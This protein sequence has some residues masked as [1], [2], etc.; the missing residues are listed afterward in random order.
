M[1]EAYGESDLLLLQAIAVSDRGCGCTL[2]EL[3]G[4]GDWLNHSVFTGEELS[5]GL[6]RLIEGGLVTL[7]E[8]RVWAT[9]RA[10]SI[11]ARASK[12]T[13]NALAARKRLGTFVEAPRGQVERQVPTSPDTG[14]LPSAG[15]CAAAIRTY[16]ER[17][18]T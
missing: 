11:Y 1:T 5:R 10:T 3:V 2:E 15:E 17:R 6:A 16:L 9:P 18:G 14:A 7:G 12:H 8:H 4:S 13:E